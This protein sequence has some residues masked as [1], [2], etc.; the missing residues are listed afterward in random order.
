ML[1]GPL[2]TAGVAVG[3]G[4]GVPVTPHP[5]AVPATS[6]T[7]AIHREMRTVDDGGTTHFP[8]LSKLLSW[9]V[10]GNRFAA[11]SRQKPIS[12]RLPLSS[13]QLPGDRS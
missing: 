2:G 12:S 7:I 4:C 10:V 1:T 9:V 3:V 8:A 13:L 11:G 6:T 5:T